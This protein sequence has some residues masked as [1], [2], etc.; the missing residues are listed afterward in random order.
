[1]KV[2]IPIL[3]EQ[4]KAES[5]QVF[6]VRPL[7]MGDTT[8]S[9]E[10]LDR[11]LN[12]LGSDL[13]EQLNTLSRDADHRPLVRLLMNPPL[14]PVTVRAQLELRRQTV[15]GRWLAVAFHVNDVHW[16]FVTELPDLWFV[17]P[18]GQTIA[19]RA[20]QV[21]EAE[22]RRREKENEP[23]PCGL[24]GRAW[25]SSISVNMTGTQSLDRQRLDLAEI[26]GGSKVGAGV[27]ELNR[28]GRCIDR[29][30]PDGLNRASYRDAEVA[31]LTQLLEREDRPSILLTGPP[32]VG[33]TTLMHEY[34][35]QKRSV[36]Q[37]DKHNTW[38]ISPQ[39]LISGMSYVGQW[40]E[41]LINILKHAKKQDHILL[42]DDLVGMFYAGQTSQSD[43]NVA[44][45]IKPFVERRDVRLVA[46][47]TPEALRVLR[48]MDRG[49]ADLF[50]VL[51]VEEP[52][53]PTTRRMLVS[54]MRTLED[55][56]R[57]QF[58]VEV[59]PAVV[60]LA[61][62][63]VRESSFPGKAADLVGQI[64]AKF[65][66][67]DVGRKNVIDVFHERSGLPRSYVDE[68]RK[69][70]R[71][72]IV[73]SLGKRV[74]GQEQALRAMADVVCIGK[75]RLGDPR[76]PLGSLLFLGPTGVGKTQSA[77]SLAT[78]LYGH[79]DRL[80]RFDMNSFNDGQA[81]AR[82][83][84]TFHEPDGQLT[85]AMRRQPFAVVLFDE[86]EKAHPD[87][88]DLLLQVL[89]EGRLTDAV[90]RT[91]DFTNAIVILTS[92]LGV[93]E[94]SQQLGFRPHDKKPASRDDVFVDAAR[95]FFRP[96]MFNRF[97][98]IVPFQPLARD[99]ASKVAEILTRDILQREGLQ[100]RRSVLRVDPSATEF[101]IDQGYD[102][103]FGARAMRRA[104]E[105]QLTRPIAARLAAMPSQASVLIDVFRGKRRLEVVTTA[106]QPATR[107]NWPPQPF[108]GMNRG[109]LLARVNAAL[110][111]IESSVDAP[112]DFTG[113]T[114]DPKQLG[115]LS[116]R[117]EIQ[118]TRR[119]ASFLTASDDRPMRNRFMP[120][121]HG[122]RPIKARPNQPAKQHV[123][124]RAAP[125]DVWG[126]LLA[127]EEPD[128][129]VKELVQRLDESEDGAIA[130]EWIDL[131]AQIVWLEAV[132]AAVQQG[133]DQRE[134]SIALY[135]RCLAPTTGCV[136]QELGQLMAQSFDLPWGLDASWHDIKA[137][138]E[139]QA[140]VLFLVGLGSAR[141]AEV[142]AGTH[143]C[144]N[145]NG[146]LSPIQ[147]IAMRCQTPTDAPG[148]IAQQE[149]DWRD[150]LLH[151]RTLLDDRPFPF[152]P[153]H[154]IVSPQRTTI[155]L[156]TGLMTRTV[157]GPVDLMT[158][159]LSQLPL[160]A[161]VNEGVKPTGDPH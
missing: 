121:Q 11:V 88:H 109:D 107:V 115:Y 49:M 120:G 26:F 146:Q 9:G 69:L 158:F 128:F 5:S 64:A 105:R 159:A 33:K 137:E 73:E 24:Q 145:P 84:G 160:P 35:F 98:R 129:Y 110:Q 85:A 117:E 136:V 75:A 104:L 45:V 50:H 27:D 133:V 89:G 83:I 82:L 134:E 114:L 150:A 40:E 2:E 154:R 17:V 61:R 74:V 47:I 106:L 44:R 37:S 123:Q 87:V 22:A 77:K 30:Y 140:G 57:C 3:V 72:T 111:R 25:T 15:R 41:R 7:F 56:Q 66:H 131:Y 147:A 36:K 31:E 23:M 151:G 78:F 20:T 51:P 93:R 100:R 71:Q 102:E 70:M 21:L 156:R 95:K 4:V 32:G 19:S 96:E 76:R 126:D 142:E 10:R 161:E 8:R 122:H 119:K 14:Q 118:D 38:L 103:Q 152:Q 46:E 155:D 58:D 16:A 63:Y 42:T 55:H 80:L 62:R 149:Q 138:G 143:L 48:E 6:R 141:L 12:R 125:P 127:A 29:M 91:A 116:L 148:V 99:D 67:K 90:G 79:A 18:R 132:S 54:H 97:D 101:V 34:V 52:D 112:A 130:G 13:R 153:I 157:Y 86:I 81:V 28:V 53:L 124:W 60:D 65:K 68:Q 108:I 1:M 92:N 94:S 135:F 139:D 39:R 43:L 113:G 144:I 59:L